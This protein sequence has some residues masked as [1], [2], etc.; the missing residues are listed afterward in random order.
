MS[1]F[2]IAGGGISGLSAALGIAAHGHHVHVVERKSSFV[3][4][5]A[6]IQLAPNAFRALDCLGVGDQVR[7]A[8]V[9]VADLTLLD[10][11]SGQVLARLPL[12]EEYRE[13]FGDS[14][15]VVERG[16][17]YAPLLAACRDHPLVTL[18]AG[19]G[20]VGYSQTSDSVQCRLS[21]GP[22]ID[23]DALVGAD[24]IWSTV[25]QQLLG[26]GPPDVSGHT[27]YRTVIPMTSVP[28][29]LRSNSVRLWAGPGW[30]VVCYPIASGTKLNLAAV[31]DN[32]ATTAVSALSVSDEQVRSAFPGLCRTPRQLLELGTG[33]KTWV[34]CDRA[35]VAR[36]ASGRVVL[37]GDAAHPMLQYAAQGAAMALEDAVALGALLNHAA[38]EIAEAFDRFTALR[39]DRTARTQ[40]VSRW[41]GQAIYHPSGPDAESRTARLASLSTHDLLDTV[42]WLHGSS[43]QKGTT[44]HGDSPH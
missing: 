25:R 27:I 40:L 26:D 44:S 21:S 39:R 29:E 15:A 32:G 8:A 12:G 36:W 11:L 4:L 1:R 35:P 6:G 38:T 24:G 19:A 5:G 43:D 42:A 3:E 28:A 30:H 33:W 41:L 37:I 14:Y 17:L 7:A 18:T 20:L 23:A 16:D 2:V 34:L 10:G 22:H 9:P 31:R 13:R